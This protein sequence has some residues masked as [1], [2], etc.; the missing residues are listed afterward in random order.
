MAA[1][2]PW[3]KC[4][5]SGYAAKGADARRRDDGDVCRIVKERQRRRCALGGVTLRASGNYGRMAAS[6][7]LR[8]GSCIASSSLLALTR[9]SHVPDPPHFHH[10]LLE[11]HDRPDLVLAEHMVG[12]LRGREHRLNA[13]VGRLHAVLAHP[14]QD[15]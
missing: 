1:S 9:N 10:G 11:S 15:V 6:R 12:G 13:L 4:D 2:S 14:I 7:F 5:G 8:D 3:W